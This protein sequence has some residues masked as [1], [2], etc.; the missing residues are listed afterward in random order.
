[1]FSF[2]CGGR[3]TSCS[4]YIC[5]SKAVTEFRDSEMKG[6]VL[7]LLLFLV[8]RLAHSA[9]NGSSSIAPLSLEAVE[10]EE[11]AEGGLGSVLGGQG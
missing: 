4:C 5:S 9:S 1:M 6:L 3:D 7:L 11:E 10:W 8:A 2:C